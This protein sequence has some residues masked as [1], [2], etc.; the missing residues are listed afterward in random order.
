MVSC[1]E[2]RDYDFNDVAFYELVREINF[3][4][5]HKRQNISLHLNYLHVSFVRIISIL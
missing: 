1:G 4:V 2:M 5:N 3:N